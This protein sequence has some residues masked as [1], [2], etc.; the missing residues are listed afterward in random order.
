MMNPTLP[1][2]MQPVEPSRSRTPRR[3]SR[4]EMILFRSPNFLISN[5]LLDVSVTS[6]WDHR[7]YLGRGSAARE[8]E[9][10]MAVHR[11]K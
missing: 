9:Q 2:L 10:G 7:I 3:C 6:G 4:F 5:S 1:T 8:S 11:R